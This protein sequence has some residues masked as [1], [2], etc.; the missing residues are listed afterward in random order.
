MRTIFVLFDSL[1][2]RMLEPYGT[3]LLETPNFKRLASRTVTFD[4][5]YVGSLPCMPARRDLQ[6]GRLS[7]LHR[8]WG[9]MEPFD[10]SL[11]QMLKERG[12]YS[13]LI[14][15]HLHYFEDGGA[16]YHTRF[17]SFEFV[18]GQEAD[19][20]KAM[21]QPPWERLRE[22]YNAK[23]YSERPGNAFFHNIVNREYIKTE[24]DFPSVQCF[25][26]GLEFLEAN[27]H[28]DGWFLQIET[29]DPHEPFHAPD[30]LRERF[31]TS[32]RGGTRDWPPY[33]RVTEHKEECEELKANYLA[34]ITLCDEQ[35]GK[36]I[37]RMDALD[38]WR[39]T[40][41]VVTT[42]HGYLL[43][44]HGWW[45]KNRMHVYQE[46]AHIPLFVHHPAFAHM[47]G[48]RRGGLTQTIDL[49]P[50]FLEAFGIPVPEEVTGRSLLAMMSDPDARLHESIIYGHFG[51]AVNITDGQCTY[52]RYP[53]EMKAQELYQYT[54]MPTHMLQFFT[55]EEIASARLDKGSAF[56]RGMPLLKVPV[57]PTSPWYQSHGPAR[58]EDSQTVLFDLDTDPE[59]LRPL[60]RPDVE[61]RLL[62]ELVRRLDEVDAPEETYRRFDLL[63]AAGGA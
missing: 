7:F 4:R 39:D 15:D 43:G 57:T 35:I 2:R 51:G 10:L 44:E 30:R 23:Q 22:Q 17:N 61:A 45:A 26:L 11:P 33:S 27:R 41:V 32:Y 40:M 52:F 24:E 56:S 3:D 62:R 12:I 37:D 59:Q 21:V 38:L 49:M 9:P 29:F 8:S 16:T 60:H 46:I 50:T 54:L 18:R 25:G 31:K 42:D 34:L 47:Q 14:T 58:M 28:A 63:G 53:R 1:N 20:W 48:T 36:L 13:H 6:S 5:H 55:E 19:T